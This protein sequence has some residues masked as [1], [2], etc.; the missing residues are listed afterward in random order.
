MLLKNDTLANLRRDLGPIAWFEL[1][2]LGH[3]LLREPHLF[4]AWGE[5]LVRAPGAWRKRRWIQQTRVVGDEEIHR[6]FV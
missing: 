2:Q 6:W 3:L 5:F 1:L 4:R